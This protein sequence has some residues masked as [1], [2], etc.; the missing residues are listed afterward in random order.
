MQC[1]GCCC[2]LHRLD[3]RF[4]QVDVRLLQASGAC[5]PGSAHRALTVRRRLLPV[6]PCRHRAELDRLHRKRGQ[7]AKRWDA[8]YRWG[9]EGE[10]QN[11]SSGGRIDG[12][13]EACACLLVP[14]ACGRALLSGIVPL[15]SGAAVRL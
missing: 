5:L 10:G 9:R 3:T 2:D 11:D 14:G 8:A 12:S 4:E 6:L 7:R 13:Q 1:L 15:W